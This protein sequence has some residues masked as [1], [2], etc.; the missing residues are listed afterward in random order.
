MPAHPAPCGWSNEPELYLGSAMPCPTTV[1][2]ESDA[3]TLEVAGGA[4]GAIGG[5][6]GC[7]SLSSG[8]GG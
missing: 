4:G 7:A 3:G 5:Y 8:I 6:V 2:A 1:C